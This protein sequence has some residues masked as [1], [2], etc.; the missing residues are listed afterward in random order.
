MQPQEGRREP[1]AGRAATV[2]AWSS[3]SWPTSP[4]PRWRASGWR[5]PTCAPAPR[6]PSPSTCATTPCRAWRAAQPRASASAPASTTAGASPRRSDD[7][8]DAVRRAAQQAVEV[9]RASAQVRGTGGRSPR[10][11]ASTTPGR[12]S[13][14]WTTPHERDP[15]EVPLE[16]KIGHLLAAA[17]AARAAAPCLSFVDATTDAWRTATASGRPRGPA[18][19]RRCCRCGG[20]LSAYAV[21]GGEVQR[22]CWPNSFRGQFETG[23]WERVLL[24]D[25]VGGAGA[26]RP[27]GRRPARRPRPAAARGRGAAARL[28]PARAAGA[29]VDRPRPRARPH[30][31]QRGGLRRHQLGAGRR[32]RAAALRLAAGDGHRRRDHAVRDGHVRLRRRGRARRQRAARQRRPADRLPHRPGARRRAGRAQQ[33]HGARRQLGHASR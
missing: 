23:G 27:G 8:P 3:P 26:G 11:A 9:A 28:R 12:P 16:E 33:R 19:T 22:R 14:T 17:A 24:L 4:S 21:G 6:T 18:S 31:R 10:S 15:L 7:A 30:P 13:R 20:G 2:R 1:R 32:P 29:R 25:L 5:T